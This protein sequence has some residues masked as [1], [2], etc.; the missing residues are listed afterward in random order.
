MFVLE[1]RLCSFVLRIEIQ[2]VNDDIDISRVVV[3]IDMMKK[4]I[5]VVHIIIHIS[6]FML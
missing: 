1:N 4:A 3:I 6:T 2:S 5:M